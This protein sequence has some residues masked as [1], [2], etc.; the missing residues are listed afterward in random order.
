M[1]ATPSELTAVPG[2]PGWLRSPVIDDN[3][4]GGR[5]GKLQEARERI[6]GSFDTRHYHV[7]S[8]LMPDDDAPV[9]EVW[10]DAQR[11]KL[12]ADSAKSPY[13]V[14]TSVLESVTFEYHPY[15]VFVAPREDTADVIRRFR[16]G[17]HAESDVAYLDS[18]VSKVEA[19]ERITPVSIPELSP[20]HVRLVFLDPISI[21]VARELGKLFP[22]LTATGDADFK[23]AS[24]GME[25]Y[26]SEMDED[27]DEDVLAERFFGDQEIFLWWD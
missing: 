12:K 5:H 9:P 17:S 6:L 25:N 10:E 27:S 26:L 19:I 22:F 4:Q 21:E 24:I 14:P 18:V 1:S 20:A 16:V 2:K 13:P 8:G 7:F 23:D 15:R 11:A 3:S